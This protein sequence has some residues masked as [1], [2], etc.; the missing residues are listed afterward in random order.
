M[1]HFSVFFVE[2]VE[3]IVD[4]WKLWGIHVKYRKSGYWCWSCMW[5]WSVLHRA[6]SSISL[7][8]HSSVPFNSIL[9]ALRLRTGYSTTGTRMQLSAVELCPLEE[10]FLN[11]VNNHFAEVSFAWSRSLSTKN[12]TPHFNLF[13]N[14]LSQIC[15]TELKLAHPW[16]SYMLCWIGNKYVFTLHFFLQP[17]YLLNFDTLGWWGH[18][19]M[20]R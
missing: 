10:H 18:N 4:N 9:I 13:N 1:S 17:V 6:T 19:A 12:E 2:D 11:N 7:T 5:S 15:S 14:D 8:E 3:L 16:T 20:A